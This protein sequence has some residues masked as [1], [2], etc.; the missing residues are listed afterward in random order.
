MPKVPVISIIDDDESVRV[1]TKRL[2]RSLGFIGH[3][4]A[5]ADAFLQS[6]YMQRNGMRDC[7]RANAGHERRGAAK[8]VD[9]RRQP[10]ADDL[11]YG[12][13]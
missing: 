12:L 13:P 4:F 8:P 5:S 2:V 1:A 9:R 3:T 10:F 11:H 6:P 7:R